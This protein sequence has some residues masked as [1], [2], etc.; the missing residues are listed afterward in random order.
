MLQVMYIQYLSEELI[1]T[2][3]TDAI[4]WLKVHHFIE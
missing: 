2:K 1:V 3:D 4:K